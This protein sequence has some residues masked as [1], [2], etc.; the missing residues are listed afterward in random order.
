MIQRLERDKLDSV[1]L[2]ALFVEQRGNYELWCGKYDL[3]RA[4]VKAAKKSPICL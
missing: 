4:Y 1:S 2:S 3:D